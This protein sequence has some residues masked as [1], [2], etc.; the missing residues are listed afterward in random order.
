MQ[1]TEPK[2]RSSDS[3]AS[4]EARA[5]ALRLQEE[6]KEL[7]EQMRQAWEHLKEAQRPKAP[8]PS[9]ESQ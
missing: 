9:E 3:I 2:P 8:E 7:F 1:M 5:L 6:D 4:D